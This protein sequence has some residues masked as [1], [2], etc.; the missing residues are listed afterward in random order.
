MKGL[1][2]R[3]NRY[4]MTITFGETIGELILD[5]LLVG[6]DK[7]NLK[8]VTTREN[9][10]YKPEVK[11]CR[12]D[13]PGYRHNFY[14]WEKRKSNKIQ[15]C[16]PF[17]TLINTACDQVIMTLHFRAYFLWLL[18][19]FTAWLRTILQSQVFLI[20][21]HMYDRVMLLTKFYHALNSTTPCPG[22]TH[23]PSLSRFTCANIPLGSSLFFISLCWWGRLTKSCQSLGLF[24]L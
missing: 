20:K 3:D 1:F 2:F 19:L 22:H 16:K 15:A 6:L 21:G 17:G 11:L 9:Y 18:P 14:G 5:P 7:P 8:K 23:S 10:L 12:E 4:L 13:H 24:L